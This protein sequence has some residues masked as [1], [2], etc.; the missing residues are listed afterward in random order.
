MH[1]AVNIHTHTHARTRK[2]G[3]AEGTIQRPELL[4][5]TNL[6][7]FSGIASWSSGSQADFR[8]IQE[9][10]DREREQLRQEKLG[11]GKTGSG[12]ETEARVFANRT[13]TENT[14]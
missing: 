8:W 4:S 7:G 11:A 1:T 2:S 12:S 5:Q 3:I 14:E 10:R 9:E 13:E 6:S